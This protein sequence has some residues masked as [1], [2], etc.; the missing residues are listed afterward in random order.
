[1]KAK[2]PTKDSRQRTHPPPPLPVAVGQEANRVRVV[3]SLI[4]QQLG[5][6][7]VVVFRLIVLIDS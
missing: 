3:P 5:L 4:S 7:Q 1:M 6:L 2:Q